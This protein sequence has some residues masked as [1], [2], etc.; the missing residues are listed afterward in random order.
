MNRYARRLALSRSLVGEGFGASQ[1]PRRFSR[2]T[3]ARPFFRKLPKVITR[4]PRTLG[5]R[6]APS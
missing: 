5:T 4:F 2:A 3:L 6:K 1:R